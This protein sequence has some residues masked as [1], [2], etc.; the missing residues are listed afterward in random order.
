MKTKSYLVFNGNAEE[1]LNFYAR[2]FN[3]TISGILR[4][5]DCQDMRPI[6]DY[7]DKLVFSDLHFNG[8][9]IG[10]ADTLPTIKVDFSSAGHAIGIFCD[11]ELQLKDIYNKLSIEG[12]IQRELYNPSFA[13]LYAE[14]IDKFGVSWGL[15]ME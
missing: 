15:I 4:Y 11:T 3:G 6:A 13:K 8:C 7:D 14:I 5:R 2:V 10:L 1:A 12:K 9:T